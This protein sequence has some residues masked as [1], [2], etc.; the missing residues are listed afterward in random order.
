MRSSGDLGSALWSSSFL[1]NNCVSSDFLA[2]C[3]PRLPASSGGRSTSPLPQASPWE[4]LLYL[5][6]QT[7]SPRRVV[8]SFPLDV[9]RGAPTGQLLR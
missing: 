2:L 3:S 9:R 1:N 7:C 6:L 8:H 4:L 5:P